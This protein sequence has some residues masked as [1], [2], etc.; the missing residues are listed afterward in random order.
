MKSYIL[1]NKQD[2]LDDPELLLDLF[3]ERSAIMEYDGRLPRELAE[4]RAALCFGFH[5][6]DELLNWIKDQKEGSK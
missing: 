5:N 6:K 2:Y 4:D 1:M 3:E